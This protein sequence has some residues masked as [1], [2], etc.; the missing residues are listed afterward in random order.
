MGSRLYVQWR[1]RCLQAHNFRS[2]AA[3]GV[4]TAWLA[5]RW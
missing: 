1:R 5:V 4:M 2:A 3:Q